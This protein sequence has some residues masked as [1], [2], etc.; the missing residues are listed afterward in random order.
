MYVVFQ[1]RD[2]F[3][4][5]SLSGSVGHHQPGALFVFHLNVL[6]FPSQIGSRPKC[7][8]QIICPISVSSQVFAQFTCYLCFLIHRFLLKVL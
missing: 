6:S 2:S 7:E 1:N 8:S 5:V 4:Q 3:L